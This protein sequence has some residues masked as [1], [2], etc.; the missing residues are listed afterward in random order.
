M[1]K[2]CIYFVITSMHKAISLLVN[3]RT[4][5]VWSS[6]VFKFPQDNIMP[7]LALGSI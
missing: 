7:S 2:T 1:E 3:A 5:H 6:K 4:P